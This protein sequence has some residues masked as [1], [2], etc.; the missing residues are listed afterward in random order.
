MSLSEPPFPNETWLIQP[1]RQC[2]L[3]I[4]VRMGSGRVGRTRAKPT[5]I[6]LNARLVRG[7]T[8]L[9]RLVDDSSTSVT[10]RPFSIHF[11]SVDGRLALLQALSLAALRKLHL[12]S[13]LGGRLGRILAAGHLIE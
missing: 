8:T 3:Q 4:G 9:K 12:E 7:I 5:S 10:R 11:Q 6:G 1:G 13:A 2:G